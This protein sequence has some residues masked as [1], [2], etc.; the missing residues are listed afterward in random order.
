MLGLL[1]KR[2]IDSRIPWPV[3]TQVF[4]NEVSPAMLPSCAVIVVVPHPTA[5]ARPLELIVATL[6][7]LDDQVTPEVRFSGG[8]AV[9]FV[10]P[11][12]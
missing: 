4:V 9:W 10:V 3:P 8:T 2:L 5:V 7:V 12:A 11:I 1:G 6:G